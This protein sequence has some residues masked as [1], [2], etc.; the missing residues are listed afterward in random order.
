ML[1]QVSSL[2]VEL[3][4]VFVLAVGRLA[5]V[6]LEARSQILIHQMALPLPLATLR[7]LAV[8]SA[9]EC[10]LLVLV[11]ELARLCRQIPTE[12]GALLSLLGPL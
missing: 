9:L 8:V 4:G 3:G 11:S 5:W 10:L 7:A 1:A 12:V 6:A 2:D